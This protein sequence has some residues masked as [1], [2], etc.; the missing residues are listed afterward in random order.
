MCILLAKFKMAIT[1]LEEVRT[2]PISTHNFYWGE[3]PDRNKKEGL[4]NI[5]R[6]Q[7][8]GKWLSG[9]RIVAEVCAM[10]MET[11]MKLTLIMN[12][13]FWRHGLLLYLLLDV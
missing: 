12:Q 3:G 2:N 10:N 8:Q 4:A 5:S 11:T 1:K 6:A 9:V 7:S 13:Y